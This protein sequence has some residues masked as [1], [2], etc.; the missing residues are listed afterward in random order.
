[1]SQENVELVQRGFLATMEE[2]WP[3]AVGTLDPEVLVQ[4]FDVPDAGVYHGPDGF[5]A[6]LTAWSEGWDSWRV[7]NPRFRSGG[8][9]HVIALFRM[10][11]RGGHSGLE[12]T[13]D[14]AIVYR[15]EGG[16]IVR[17]EYFNDQQQALEAVGLSE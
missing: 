5:I 8:G 10:V 16:K 11:A 7:E 2:D 14:D 9:E 17:L 15:I 4:D 3:T 1:M 6:W 12:V 13:R